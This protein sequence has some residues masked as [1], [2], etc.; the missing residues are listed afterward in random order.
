MGGEI[1]KSAGRRM[2]KKN[3]KFM[4]FVTNIYGRGIGYLRTGLQWGMMP[5]IIFVG[6]QTEPTPS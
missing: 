4:K 2:A 6:F 1:Q 5:L 3:Q